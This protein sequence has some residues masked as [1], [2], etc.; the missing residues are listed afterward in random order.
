M[1]GHDT[2]VRSYDELPRSIVVLVF[3]LILISV[4]SLWICDALGDTPT[5]NP[6]FLQFGRENRNVALFFAIYFLILAVFR[7]IQLGGHVPYE[8]LWGCN[9]G[10]AL[11]VVG[12]FTSRPLLLGAAVCTVAVD[13]FCW[14]FDVLTFFVL[15]KCK[16][17]VAKYLLW[18]ETTWMTK[19][20]ST[21]HLWFIPL[22]LYALYGY[23]GVRPWSQLLSMVVGSSLVIFCRLLTP[24]SVP[25]KELNV[26][27]SFGF[28][29]DIKAEFVHR[30]DKSPAYVYV[31]YLI[32]IGNIPLN[33]PPCF[34]LRAFSTIFF[35][36]PASNLA[37]PSNINCLNVLKILGTAIKIVG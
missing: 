10:M 23:G 22:C 13:Q 26:N 2:A 24:K 9:V 37:N 3:G 15:G 21:H 30:Y 12:V 29:K 27:C 35:L 6:S 4:M 28:W 1:K 36:H 19:L 16:V 17:G 18:P 31:P 14:Y 5:A 8:M 7:T 33:S 32:F 20:T 34:I 11:V 25:G